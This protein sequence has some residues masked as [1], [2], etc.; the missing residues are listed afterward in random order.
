M[1]EVRGVDFSYGPLQVLFEVNLAIPRGSRV[2]LLGTNGCGKSTLLRVVAGLLRPSRGTVHFDGTD[3]TALRGHQRARL[4]MT[5]V[6][7]GRATFPSLSLLD[8]LRMGA[9]PFLGDRRRVEERVDEVVSWFPQLGTR[10]DQPAGTLSGGEQQM[11]VLGRALMGS[12]ELLMIDELSLGLAPLV[13]Q[14]IVKVLEG[15]AALG[16][17]I[18][19]V[20]QSVNIALNLAEDAHF[21]DRGEI[22]FSGPTSRLVDSD[23]MRSAFFGDQSGPRKN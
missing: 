20:E 2:V 6:E 19:L 1:L 22:R 10:L 23:L 13:M 14:E 7:G 18:F 11:V 16:R 12:A 3:V 21:M 17:T 9:Y 4:G 8:N 5:L 15:V